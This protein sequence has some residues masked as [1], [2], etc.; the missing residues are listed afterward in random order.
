MGM[1]Y[2]E[3]QEQ[4]VLFYWM[5]LG[6][7]AFV[8]VAVLLYVWSVLGPVREERPAR[9]DATPRPAPAE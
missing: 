8:A 6:A 5:R 7:G 1:M 2:M 4:L 9:L 3:V